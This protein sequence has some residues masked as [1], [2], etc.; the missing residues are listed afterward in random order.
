M[1]IKVI[2]DLQLTLLKLLSELDQEAWLGG[3]K[4]ELEYPVEWKEGY[5]GILWASCQI[6]N[7]KKYEKISDFQWSLWPDPVLNVI[8]IIGLMTLVVLFFITLIIV[9][10]KRKLKVNNLFF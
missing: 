4:P 9:G 10:I 2:G 7:G 1:L 6:V 3:F 5:E 8:R